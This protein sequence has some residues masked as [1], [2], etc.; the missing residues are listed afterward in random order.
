MA[1][2]SKI[3]GIATVGASIVKARLVQRLIK[4]I[5]SI[6]ALAIATGLMTGS[7]LIGGF[8]VVYQ[9]LTH[10]GLEPIPAQMLVGA[11]AL[12]VLFL[13]IDRAA[14]KLRRLK[15]IPEQIVHT[16]FPLASRLDAI[17][18]SFLNGLFNP[19]PNPHHPK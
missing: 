6:I 2:L 17:A 15:N 16:E 1:N 5:A 3:L 13:L 14:V 8:Y 7:L 19:D 18:D 4:D 12:L 11:S 10:Y 9:V